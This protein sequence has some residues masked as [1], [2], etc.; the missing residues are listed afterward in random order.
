MA[1]ASASCDA[2]IVSVICVH[3]IN[4]TDQTIKFGYLAAE[5]MCTLTVFAWPAGLLRNVDLQAGS[6]PE[7]ADVDCTSR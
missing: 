7:Q 5:E 6:L 1:R 2:P 4:Q 3:D